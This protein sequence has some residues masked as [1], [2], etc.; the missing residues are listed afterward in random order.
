ML[1]LMLAAG[2]HANNDGAMQRIRRRNQLNR[3]SII[4]TLNLKSLW[5]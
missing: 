4:D 5:R 3:P 1:P 2:N